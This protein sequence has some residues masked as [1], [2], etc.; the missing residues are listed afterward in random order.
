MEEIS[1]LIEEGYE[2]EYLDFKS[3]EYSQ[4][5]KEELI[6]DSMAMAN[7]VKLPYDGHCTS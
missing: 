2:C 7:A 1:R 4:L 6:K 3:E 5:Q